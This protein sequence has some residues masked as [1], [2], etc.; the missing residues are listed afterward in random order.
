VT[1]VLGVGVETDRH[2]NATCREEQL[3]KAA[4]PGGEVELVGQAVHD[5]SVVCPVAVPYLPAQHRHGSVQ[6]SASS[7]SGAAQLPS[8][9]RRRAC[10]LHLSSDTHY[11]AQTLVAQ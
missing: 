4:L 3:V 1:V 7:S 8:A 6:T 10:M 2:A 11:G 9:A 5:T